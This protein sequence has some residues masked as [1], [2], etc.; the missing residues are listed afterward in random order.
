MNTLELLKVADAAYQAGEHSPLRDAE[1]DAIS[2]AIGF[3][4][5]T[6]PELLSLDN[7]ITADELQAWLERLPSPETPLH[8]EVKCDG[9]AGLA[10]Y[11][12]SQ[13]VSIRTR[14]QER[15]PGI[16]ELPVMPGFSGT[17]KGEL[18]S[19][20]GRPWA[21]ARIRADDHTA[22]LRFM[23][24]CSSPEEHE[25]TPEQH[26]SPWAAT[27]QGLD[28][29]TEAWEAW[30]AGELPLDGMPSDGLVLS[31]ACPNLRASLGRS[32]RAPRW[33]LALKRA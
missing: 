18:W 30:L 2:R 15:S 33:A 19:E 10:T 12:N 4:G 22:G 8:A 23:L 29:I 21:A 20:R 27:L 31:V 5:A 24:H 9:V 25:A 3:L 17:I 1:Y 16:A 14:K 32:A 7:A 6:T 26:R 11:R 28:A 13:P